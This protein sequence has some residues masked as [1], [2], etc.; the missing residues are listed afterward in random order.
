MI[1][2]MWLSNIVNGL[3]CLV[4]FNRE[5]LDRVAEE[6]NETLQES[7]QVL[8]AELSKTFGLPADFLQEV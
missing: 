2:I 4:L 6:I 5:Y 8:I 3:K 7:G 1:N